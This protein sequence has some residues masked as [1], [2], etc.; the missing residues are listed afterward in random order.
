MKFRDSKLQGS[1]KRGICWSGCKTGIYDGI[2]L[3]RECDTSEE[4]NVLKRE[5]LCKNLVWN[6]R[7]L[8]H[9]C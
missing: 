2:N 1:D 7:V 4:L 6:D 8:Q 3:T 9:L 5:N